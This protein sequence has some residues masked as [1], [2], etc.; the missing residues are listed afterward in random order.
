M[1]SDLKLN[2]FDTTFSTAAQ[3]VTAEEGIWVR[4]ERKRQS[5]RIG[6]LKK[7]RVLGRVTWENLGICDL[8]NLYLCG[9]D[10]LMNITVILFVTGTRFQ[11][12]ER[13]RSCIRF[14]KIEGSG[15]EE[16]YVWY[17]A[18]NNSATCNFH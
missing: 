7:G 18:G 10:E 15:P 9:E 12:V 3:V 16:G 4:E 5:R 14:K 2:C 13:A 6:K 11:E 8:D 1:I 17:Y